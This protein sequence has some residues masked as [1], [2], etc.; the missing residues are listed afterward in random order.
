MAYWTGWLCNCVNR[1][2][3]PDMIGE[4][5]LIT[6]FFSSHSAGRQDI[7]LGIGDDAAVLRPAP[8]D[9]LVVS[10]DTL[11][12]GTHFTEDMPAHAL[13]YRALAVNLSDMAAMGAEPLWC[14][15]A[16][17]L[18]GVDRAWL[19]GFSSGFFQL[20]RQFDV[21][22]VGGDTVCAPLATTVTIHGRAGPD[23]SVLRS[24][25]Q[26]GDG[27]FIT[28]H[29]GDALAGRKILENDPAIIPAHF[30]DRP[31]AANDELLPEL[32]DRFLYPRP[33]VSEGRSLAGIASAMIDISDGLHADLVKLLSA[34]GT[35]A[36][37]DAG[38]L[39]VSE[40]L[41]QWAGRSEAVHFALSGGDDYELCFTVPPGA[42]KQ[43]C[44]QTAA[45]QCTVT[46]IGTVTSEA[47][48]RW[49]QDG[50]PLP[51]DDAGYDHFGGGAD[52]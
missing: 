44:E 50:R 32:I 36:L 18:P 11:C 38:H 29:P 41:V 39:P 48:V 37:L 12:Q 35:G 7:V 15:L 20:A 52:A 40:S 25:A 6:E 49:Q 45:W 21:A 33:R 2:S 5:D 46:R 42:E 4:F 22:L 1:V 28:G 3:T 13:G 19:A 31:V 47:A 26:A 17:S 27:I 51:V 34:S 24:G 16:L 23:A 10:T 8:G 14:T 30:P 9:D 43:L